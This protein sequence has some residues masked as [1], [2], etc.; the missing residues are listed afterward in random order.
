MVRKL[1]QICE[2][3]RSRDREIVTSRRSTSVDMLGFVLCCLYVYHGMGD[4]QFGFCGFVNAFW[5]DGRAGDEKVKLTNGAD[6]G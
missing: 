2:C 4:F 5:W 3:V 1:W 6:S